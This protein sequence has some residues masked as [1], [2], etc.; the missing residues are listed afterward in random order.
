MLNNASIITRGKR[1]IHLEYNGKIAIV[2]DILYINV[3]ENGLYIIDFT[4]PFIKKIN[5]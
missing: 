1:T 3:F 4:L 2:F 5:K